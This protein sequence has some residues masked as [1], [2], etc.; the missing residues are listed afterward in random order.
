MRALPP[1]RPR[2]KAPRAGIKNSIGLS[3]EWLFF[4]LYRHPAL[5]EPDRLLRLGPVMVSKSVSAGKK[6]DPA[7]DL[8]NESQAAHWSH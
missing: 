5:V 3:K 1:A 4:Q 8:A 6:G 7:T 2:M